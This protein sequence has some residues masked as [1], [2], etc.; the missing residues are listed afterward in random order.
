MLAVGFPLG[1][2][3]RTIAS[4]PPLK[5]AIQLL[6]SYSNYSQKTWRQHQLTGCWRTTPKDHT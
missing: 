1:T 3:S 5:L 6:A 2:A 4:S